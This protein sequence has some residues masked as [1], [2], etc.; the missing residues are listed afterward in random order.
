LRIREYAY[1]FTPH[2]GGLRRRDRGFTTETQRG[3][4]SPDRETAARGKSLRLRRKLSRLSH[5]VEMKTPGY[6]K[7]LSVLSVFSVV[8]RQGKI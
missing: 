1:D 7:I 2:Y 4:V 5:T 8:S 6:E 3:L